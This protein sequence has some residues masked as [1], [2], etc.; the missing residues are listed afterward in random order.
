MNIFM[1]GANGIVGSELLLLLLEKGHR[2][3]CLVRARERKSGEERLESAI[4]RE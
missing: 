3:T 1:T 4:G 2:V